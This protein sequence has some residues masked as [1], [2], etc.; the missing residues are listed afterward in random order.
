MSG[1]FGLPMSNLRFEQQGFQRTVSRGSRRHLGRFL[2]IIALAGFCLFAGLATSA[3]AATV[4]LFAAPAAA[5]AGDCSSPANACTIDTAV[6]NANAVAVTDSVQIKVARGNYL[7]PT[8]NP[9]ALPITFAGPSLTLEAEKG[10]P[11][12][13]G[14]KTVRVLSVSAASNVTIDGLQIEF[15]LTAGLGGGIENAGKL[16]VKNS[17]FSSN[18]AGNGGAISNGATGTLT[19]QDSTLSHNGTT[20][21]GGGAIIN[22]GAATIIRSAIVNNSV[23]INGGGINVQPGGT[24]T[25]SNSTVAGNTSG[26]LGGGLSNLGTLNIQSSTIADN[27]ATGGAAMAS[28]NLNVTFAATIIGAQSSPNACNPANAAIVD[29]G[30]NLDSDGS[31]ISPTAPAPGSHNGTTPYGPSTYGAALDAYLGGGLANNGGPTKTFALLNSPSPLTTLANP[32]LDIVPPGFNLPAPIGGVSAACSLS[33]QRGVVPAAGINCDIGAYLLQATRTALTASSAKVGQNASV[34]YTATV[35]PTP[36]RGTVSFNDGA[37]NPATANCAAQPLSSGKATCTVS[38]KK[39]GSYPVT[40]TYSGDGAMNNYAASTSVATTTKVVDRKKPSAPG[41]L[42]AQIR[43]GKLKLSWGAS[44][45]NVKIQGYQVLRNS[46][47]VVKKTKAKV[48]SASVRVAF[49]GGVYAVRAV[50]TAGNVSPLSKKVTVKLVNRKKKT[51][52]I[53]KNAKHGKHGKN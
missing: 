39:I 28:G 35:A 42:K 29:G 6:T 12:L 17:T 37:G 20:G 11:T 8:A 36:D 13:S 32:A 44:K 1:E 18:T 19:V 33:D 15:G 30:Y 10:T 34:T 26:G 53:V 51:Y 3:Q 4:G 23:P 46:H 5:G 45:D 52:R 9:T 41:K 43:G 24:T 47:N 40:A 50:D 22:S 7:L 48:R 27:T 16:T 49:Y 25:L 2:S 21:V 14:V 38:Y 31:C